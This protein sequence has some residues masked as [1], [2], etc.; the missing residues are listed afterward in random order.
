MNKSKMLI[1]SFE[2]PSMLFEI[3]YINKTFT[4]CSHK[5]KYKA[6]V[7]TTNNLNA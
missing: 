1:F 4:L 3:A 7:A 5:A 6:G 2:I